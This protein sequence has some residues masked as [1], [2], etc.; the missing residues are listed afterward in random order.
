[1]KLSGWI[2]LGLGAYYVIAGL[3]YALTSEFVNGFP[4]LITAAIGIGVFGGYA[5][6]TVRRGEQALAA[7]EAAAEPVEPHIGSTIWPFGYA[8]SAIGIVVG[9]LAY[10][11]MYAVGGVLF[12]AATVGWFADV[13]HQWRHS[14]EEPP[15]AGAP[16]GP[17]TTPL[18]GESIV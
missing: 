18:P 14:H 4:L 3:G 11:P 12:V 5:Y 17:D 9:F 6:L 15:E 13:R 2:G 8:L 1:M 16:P 7:G 10:Q